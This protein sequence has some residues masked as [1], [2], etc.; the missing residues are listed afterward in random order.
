MLYCRSTWDSRL[1]VPLCT[2]PRKPLC[3]LTLAR[4]KTVS[5]ERSQN[6]LWRAVLWLHGP[7]ACLPSLHLSSVIR[8][9]TV[10]TTVPTHTKLY[11][12]PNRVFGFRLRLLLC[13]LC[14]YVLSHCL[15]TRLY[16]IDSLSATFSPLKYLV[17]LYLLVWQYAEQSCCNHHGPRYKFS[18]VRLPHY[19]LYQQGQGLF[20]ALPNTGR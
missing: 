18:F 2:L 19:L 20:L 14:M 10:R 5:R 3:G 6:L 16:I 7:D 9:C 17:G 1:S 15:K 12:Q 13:D 11:P 4:R 8:V